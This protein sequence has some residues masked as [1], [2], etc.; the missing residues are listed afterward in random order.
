VRWD[1]GDI[2]DFLLKISGGFI[3]CKKVCWDLDWFLWLRHLIH[4]MLPGAYKR[5]RAG[6]KAASLFL[7]VTC[8][9][10]HGEFFLHNET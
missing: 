6:L 9:Y 3:P 8:N 5:L 4:W 1:L 10:C 7:I 2:E